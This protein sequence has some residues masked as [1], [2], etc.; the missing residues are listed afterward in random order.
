MENI[1]AKIYLSDITYINIRIYIRI[2]SKYIEFIKSIYFFTRNYIDDILNKNFFLK[3]YLVTLFY[4]Y[5]FYKIKVLWNDFQMHLEMLECI[6]RM[7][8]WYVVI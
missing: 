4:S 1:K 5:S 8:Y 3:I 2:F 6:N 7:L